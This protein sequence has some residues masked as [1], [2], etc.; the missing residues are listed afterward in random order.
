AIMIIEAEFDDEGNLIQETF[1]KKEG[2]PEVIP[3]L[4]KG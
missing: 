1:L 2:A 4:A 3:E